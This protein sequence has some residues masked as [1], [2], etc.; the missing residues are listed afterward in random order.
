MNKATLREIHA[1]NKFIKT[2]PLKVAAKFLCL[3]Y[4]PARISPLLGDV[5][6]AC[7]YDP[8]CPGVRL[9]DPTW[10]DEF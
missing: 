10:R 6:W 3:N 8:V 7:M 2:R 5:F 1:R 4:C 9:E